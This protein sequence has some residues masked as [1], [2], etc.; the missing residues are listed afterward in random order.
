VDFDLVIRNGFVVDGSGTPGTSADI[1]IVGDR[2]VAVGDVDGTA[3]E[4]IDADGLAVAPGFVDGHTHMDAQLFWD[5]LGTSSCWHGVTTVVMGNCGFTLAP[6]RPEERALVLRNLERAEDIP[7]EAMRE[8]ITWAWSTFGEYLDAVDTVPK[9]LNYAGSIG[10]SALRTWAMGDRAFEGPATEHDLAAM[11]HELSDALRAGAFGF[12]TSRSPSHATSDDRPV[13]SRLASW[14][15]VVELVGLVGREST[16]IFQLAPEPVDRLDAAAGAD[17]YGRLKQLALSTGVPVVFGVAAT[18][19]WLGAV[20]AIDDTVASGGEMF[21][22]TNCRG[23]STLQ[24]FRTRLSFDTIP[25]WQEIRSRTLPEQRTALRDPVVRDR[26]TWAAHHGHYGHAVGAEPPRPDY[27][28]VR[29]MRSPYLP[30]PSVADEAR[31]RRL[32]PVE[33]MIDVALEH[34][35]DVFFHQE[36]KP[37]DDD[38]L[39]ALMRNPNTAMTFSD[40]GAHVSQI[41]DASIQTH[42]LAYWVRERHALTLEEAIRMMTYQPASIWRLHDRGRLAPGYAADV[43]IFDPDTVAPLMPRLVTDLPG[44]LRRLEQRAQGYAATVVNG[45]VLTRDGEPADARPGRL[46]RAGRMPSPT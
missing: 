13:A 35:F 34:D 2:I 26:L 30:N 25:E 16:A 31:R 12:T 4:E 15:E 19:A 17:Y 40:A 9:G 41:C 29:I 3:R 46:L 38:E 22:L 21:G 23:A 28:H 32:D 5:D 7:A 39:V 27:E 1:A 14:T 11:K 20:A 45:V 37:Q 10:H 24:S 42:L 44:G 43:T 6:A 18:P 33:V 36:R 8:G